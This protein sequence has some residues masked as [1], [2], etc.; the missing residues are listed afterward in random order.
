MDEPRVLPSFIEAQ[1]IMAGFEA[2]DV[3]PLASVQMLIELLNDTD[4]SVAASLMWL[5]FETLGE[6][7]LNIITSAFLAGTLRER[8]AASE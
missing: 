5:F 4:G 3:D 7:P 2:E 6:H 1:R 8:D